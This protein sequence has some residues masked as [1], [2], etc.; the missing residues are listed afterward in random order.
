MSAN[1]ASFTDHKV[2]RLKRRLNQPAATPRAASILSDMSDGNLVTEF[3]FSFAGFTYAGSSLV[4]TIIGLLGDNPDG[5][6]LFDD[7]IAKIAGCNERTV[8]RWRKAYLDEAKGTEEKKGTNFYPLEIIEGEY[9]HAKERYEKTLYRITFAE[10]LEQAVAAARA[11]ADYQTDRLHALE[12]AALFHYEDIPQAPPPGRKRKPA[13]AIQT[14]IADLNRA[15]K[16]IIAAQTSLKEMPAAQRAAFADA[17]SGELR[18]ALEQ[19]REQ[20]AEFEALLSGTSTTVEKEEVKD[21]PDILSGIPPDTGA[22]SVRVLR[23]ETRTLP[24]REHTPEDHAAFD[25]LLARAKHK[26]QVTRTNVEIVALATTDLP[27]ELEYVPDA[28]EPTLTEFDAVADT[29]QDDGLLAEIPE[30]EKPP[31]VTFSEEDHAPPK[32]KMERDIEEQGGTA[33]Y[34]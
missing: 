6:K 8:R 18:A 29:K 1:I 19:I 28:P 25:S 11:R 24:Q 10:P 22:G 13:R 21:I 32:S 2:G 27:H 3:F 4:L 33:H 34:F 12:E 7:D 5:I 17:Q 20:M 16:K 26:P 30:M 9:N 15:A 23:E 14:P 31:I